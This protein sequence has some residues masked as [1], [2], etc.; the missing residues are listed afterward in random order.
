MDIHPRRADFTSQVNSPPG[1]APAFYWPC[2][3]NR[4]DLLRCLHR[5]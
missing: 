3:Q 1:S 4:L 5:P 2:V